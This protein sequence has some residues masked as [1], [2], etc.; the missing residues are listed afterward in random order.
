[1]KQPKISY[2][3]MSAHIV[4]LV[5][6]SV[7]LG[8]VVAYGIWLAL[9]VVIPLM[10]VVIKRMF[11]IYTTTLKQL[12]FIFEA[13]KSDDSSFRFSE[14]PEK[15]KNAFLN[16]SLNRIKE[17]MDHQKEQIKQREKN[18][19]LIMECANI[20]IMILRPS[21]IVVQTNTK[22]TKI[23]GIERIT[24]VE[25]LQQ[26][27]PS[28]VNV[29]YNIQPGEQKTV[30]YNTEAGETFLV[31]TCAATVMNNKSQKIITVN[32]INNELYNKE[33]QAWEKL[34]CILTHEIMN[35]LAPIA[36]I[37]TSLT[38]IQHDDEKLKQGLTTIHSTS[39]RLMKFVASFRKLEKMPRPQKAP[40]VLADIVEQT[41]KIVDTK[42]I[43]TVVH[44]NPLDIM[45]YADHSQI[46]QVMINLVKNAVEACI[47]SD[48]V[49]KSNAIEIQSYIAETEQVIIEISNTG[50]AIPHSDVENIFTPFFTTKEDGSGVGLSISRQIIHSHGGSLVLANNKNGN[51][52]FR[53]T[54]E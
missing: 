52:L 27:S 17:V 46:M 54:L 10:A 53:I 2:Y 23:F 3:K 37:S 38:T 49:S 50:N 6:V 34:T 44:L 25:K 13:V 12:N 18:F 15:T 31:L 32:N 48:I 19:E 30:H 47:S 28:L 20:G 33:V 8:I 5:A 51:V 35:S 14:D 4:M 24:H 11:F 45:I 22:A 9:A 29:L 1:M 36:S 26:L 42:S 7:L 43:K 41:L 21:G 39:D 40:I 16:Y